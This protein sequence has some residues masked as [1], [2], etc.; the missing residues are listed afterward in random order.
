MD[1]QDRVIATAAVSK[2]VDSDVFQRW[3]DA[4]QGNFSLVVLLAADAAIGV[5]S[6]VGQLSPQTL[7]KQKGH[8]PELTAAEYA[9]AQRAIQQP[10]YKIQDTPVSLIYVLDVPTGAAG[11]YV[12][13]VKAT[14]TGNA[15]FV[16]SYRR[17]SREQALRDIEIARLLEKG[18][19]VRRRLIRLV[20][21]P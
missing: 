18:E 6:L 7:R 13:V 11:S 17:L 10:T 14:Q 19:R 5:K 2:L 21:P 1:K 16:S 9:E 4:P 8:P 3:L 20:E 15:A 12:L